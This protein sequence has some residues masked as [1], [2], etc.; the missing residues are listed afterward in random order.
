[1][2]FQ[3][4]YF[5]CLLLIHLKAELTKLASENQITLNTQLKY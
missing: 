5:F 3:V 2:I 1:M 4:S